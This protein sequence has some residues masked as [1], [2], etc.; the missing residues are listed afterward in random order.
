MELFFAIFTQTQKNA[1]EATADLTDTCLVV[2]ERMT[3]LN[4][5]VARTTFEKSAE[6]GLLCLERTLVKEPR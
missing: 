1:L 4:L 5:E 2:V 6:L 3:Q